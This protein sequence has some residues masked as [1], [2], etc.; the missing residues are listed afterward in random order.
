MKVYTPLDEKKEKKAVALSS[1]IGPRQA[2]TLNLT[3]RSC[4]WY[5][6]QSVSIGEIRKWVQKHA[7]EI[8]RLGSVHVAHHGAGLFFAESMTWRGG[9]RGEMDS[10]SG[11]VT[12]DAQ[13][14]AWIAV[15]KGHTQV[16]SGQRWGGMRVSRTT[17]TNSTSS[18]RGCLINS[19]ELASSSTSTASKVS[20]LCR[21]VLVVSDKCSVFSDCSS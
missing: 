2:V 13:Q 17:L 8:E 1:S 5:T 11:P 7:K 19:S 14:S 10:E 16:P 4:L 3:A 9:Q 6:E 18:W 12:T 21:N 15:L 20:A